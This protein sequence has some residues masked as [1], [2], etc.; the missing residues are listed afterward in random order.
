[1]LE[2]VT[3]AEMVYAVVLR[4]FMKDFAFGDWIA[5]GMELNV[6]VMSSHIT[7]NGFL[8]HVSFQ[9]LMFGLCIEMLMVMFSHYNKLSLS[10]ALFGGQNHGEG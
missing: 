9:Q 4:H 3:W 5:L 6:T 10:L 2:L 8:S 7:S 1:M